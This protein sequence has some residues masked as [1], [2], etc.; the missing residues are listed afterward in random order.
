MPSKDVKGRRFE[1][2]RAIGEKRGVQPSLGVLRLC[3]LGNM[4]SAVV[5]VSVRVC[6]MVTSTQVGELRVHEGIYKS[7]GREAPAM[8]TSRSEGMPKGDQFLPRH[9]PDGVVPRV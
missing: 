3:N 1:L 6:P 4:E 7:A 8:E 2:I 9:I 5:L